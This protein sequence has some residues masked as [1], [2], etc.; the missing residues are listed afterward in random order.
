VSLSLRVSFEVNTLKVKFSSQEAD[1]VE[2][3]SQK[4]N[5]VENSS[6]KSCSNFPDNPDSRT[7]RGNPDQVSNVD[8]FPRP[9][10][11]NTKGGSITVLLTS[12][13]TGLTGQWYCD[14][15]PFSI[16]CPRTLADYGGSK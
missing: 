16:P 4:V 5:Q 14:T 10:A 6:R 3:S 12:C 8:M 9:K 2:N 15:S 7:E 1:R 13:L 11:G